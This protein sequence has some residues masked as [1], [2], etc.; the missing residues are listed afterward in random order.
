MAGSAI[1]VSRLLDHERD[2]DIPILED[3]GPVPDIGIWVDTDPDLERVF[4]I[5]RTIGGFVGRHHSESIG[6]PDIAGQVMNTRIQRTR[7][8]TQYRA[9]VSFGST[10]LGAMLAGV[11][12]ATLS[13]PVVA[14]IIKINGDVKAYRAGPEETDRA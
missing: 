12:G 7:L 14:A 1:R 13:A 6:V 9:A 5:G 3:F 4:D 10:I 2:R 8:E 11:L